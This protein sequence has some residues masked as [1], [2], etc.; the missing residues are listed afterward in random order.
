MKKNIILA[1]L[2]SPFFLQAQSVGIGTATP[3]TGTLL[4]VDLGSSF[5]KGFLITGEFNA[6]AVIP[7]TST[8]SRMF[9]FPGKAV[10]RAG[11]ALGQWD[12][13][14][15][16][17]YSFAAG[18]GTI[19][20]GIISTAFG[21]QTV[22]SGLQSMSVGYATQSKKWASFSMG[23]LTIA[24]ADASTAMGEATIAK[25]YSELVI[26]RFN[27][28]L[29][30]TTPQP[31]L[32][33]DDNALF[34]AG[35]GAGNTQRNNAMTLYKN[36]NLL[37]KNPAA[38]ETII[39]ANIQPPPVSG[40]GTRMMWLPA[41]SA[42]RVGTLSD[43]PG[44]PEQEQNN[45]DKDSI[46]GW[47]FATGTSTLAKGNT[48]TA[49]G[50]YTAALGGYSVA[51]GAQTVA[52]P[53]ASTAI[54]S[55]N[56]TTGYI[57]KTSWVATDPLFYIGNTAPG[58]GLRSNAMVVLKNGNTG[59]GANNPGTNKLEVN[60]NTQ[61]DSLQISNGNKFSKMQGG[62]ITVGSSVSAIK[63]AIITFPVSFATVPRI[64]CTVVNDDPLQPNTNDTWVVSIR[65][66]S[67]TQCTV[68]VVRVDATLG[69]ST[70][71]HLN[72]FAF[73]N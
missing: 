48:A 10:F 58:S 50:Y 19:A 12:D 20:S 65:N 32:W 31:F 27:D 63:T 71:A 38:V 51:M 64:V 22:A 34:T 61:T 66:I 36:G 72:W 54:G 49:M 14:N 5:N 16:G 56:D 8:N 55:R 15:C 25:S 44:T 52:A 73:T 11:A 26:G 57:S 6:A 70:I 3:N 46:G 62:I 35:N 33:E 1:V 45:W 7:T 59:I 53:Y 2:L 18:S 60:G 68:N 30:A 9:F 42:F 43:N 67:A 4:H 17:P 69:W 29:A 23:K 13:A 40:I 28:T 41:L 47:S 21:Q 24:D 37:L 39:I